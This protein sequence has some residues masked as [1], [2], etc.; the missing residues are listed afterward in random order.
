MTST[1]QQTTQKQQQTTTQH[2]KDVLDEYTDE[3][4]CGD[5]H[6]VDDEICKIV[7]DRYILNVVGKLEHNGVLP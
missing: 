1:T 7:E 4:L 2:N 5:S 6:Y 3:E